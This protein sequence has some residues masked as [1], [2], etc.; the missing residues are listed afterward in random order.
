MIDNVE[1]IKV[2]TYNV[3][4]CRGLDGRINPERIAKVIQ[5]ADPDLVALQELD[6]NRASTNNIDQPASIAE[7]L[8][9]DYH[10]QPAIAVNNEHYG[11]GILSR[12]PFQVIKAQHLS[13][14][15]PVNNICKTLPI[16]QYLYEPREVIWI[17]VQIKDHFV[18]FF[19]THLGLRSTERR[20]HMREIVS[21]QWLGS[22][23]KTSPTILCGDFN[24]G[25]RSAEMKA[26]FQ[27]LREA[28]ASFQNN[29]VKK[30]FPSM[31]PFKELD[32]VFY[33]KYLHLSSAKVIAT[34][35]SRVASDHLPLMAEFQI[36]GD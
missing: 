8:K 28:K 9:M 22:V 12:Y 21:E 30:T 7:F 35:L 4:S 1:T 25:P 24:A 2:M 18:N 32:H 17:M 31:I 26:L 6:V 5:E 3:H 27:Y 11:I 33:N 19:N 23:H 20:Q 14:D 36:S 10:F 34:K 29:Q 13:Q 15:M 16:I